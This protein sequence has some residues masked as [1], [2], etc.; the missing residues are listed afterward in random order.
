MRNIGNGA[1]R[2]LANNLA[3]NLV[4]TFRRF[5]HSKIGGWR[6]SAIEVNV[7]SPR[8]IELFYHERDGIILGN[9]GLMRSSGEELK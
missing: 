6:K 8:A 9:A 7:N 4:I 5:D 1:S 3:K 2:N